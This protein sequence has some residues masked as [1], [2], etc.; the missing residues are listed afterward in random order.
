MIL[1]LT[2]LYFPWSNVSTTN[3]VDIVRSSAAMVGLIIILI[4][5]ISQ[6]TRSQ[7]KSFLELKDVM[8]LKEETRYFILNIM[9]CIS[10]VK[11][12]NSSL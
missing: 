10:T 2:Y 4:S 8:I 5:S 9:V 7:K 3:T 1:Y 6:P 11:I 12:Y